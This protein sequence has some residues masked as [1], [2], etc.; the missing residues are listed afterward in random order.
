MSFGGLAARAALLKE[1]IKKKP[2]KRCGLQYNHKELDKCPHCGELDEHALARLL[3]RRENEF[4]ANKS[5]GF[6]FLLGAV[7]LLI[8]VVIGSGG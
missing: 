2:C 8:V 6:W 3:E 7:V 1:Q 4:Q 5:L